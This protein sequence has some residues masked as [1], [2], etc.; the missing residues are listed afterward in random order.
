MFETA[1]LCQ[2]SVFNLKLQLQVQI[3]DIIYTSILLL[4][5]LLTLENILSVFPG[6]TNEMDK[7]KINTKGRN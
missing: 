6:K 1:D 7:D 4:Y 3:K 2:M 5:Y